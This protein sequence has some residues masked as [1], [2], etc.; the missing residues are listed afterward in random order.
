[1]SKRIFFDTNPIIYYLE[2]HTN[3]S[4]IVVDFIIEHKTSGDEFYTSTITNAEYLYKPFRERR[5]DLL[6]VYS[7][8]L[9]IYDFKVSP[10]TESI[11]FKSAQLRSK[12]SGLK[13]PDALQLA[14]AIECQCHLFL[15]NDERLA[16]VEEANVLCLS[17][18]MN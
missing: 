11:A 13:L 7:D 16:Q 8:F 2:T 18:L 5:L 10:I 14:T 1:M 3:Y 9:N 4:D 6:K 12:Y 15:T 17:R